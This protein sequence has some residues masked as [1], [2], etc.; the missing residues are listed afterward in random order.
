MDD[1]YIKMVEERDTFLTLFQDGYL[2][3]M[4][5]RA[6]YDIV[7][8]LTRLMRV[9]E[10]L[11][12]HSYP[13]K[14]K[15]QLVE[16]FII[17]RDIDDEFRSKRIEIINNMTGDFNA[18]KENRN[19]FKGYVKVKIAELV[20][21]MFENNLSDPNCMVN[22]FNACTEYAESINKANTTD[23]CIKLVKVLCDKLGSSNNPAIMNAI[24]EFK[25]DITN[26]IGMNGNTL[27][28]EMLQKRSKGYKYPYSMEKRIS[29]KLSEKEKIKLFEKTSET[30][31]DILISYI[32]LEIMMLDS[33]SMVDGAK[34]V[35]FF[36]KTNTAYFIVLRTLLEENPD[37]IN[38]E[39]FM[40]NVNDIMSRYDNDMAIKKLG[41]KL[42]KKLTDKKA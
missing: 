27:Y 38:N 6:N 18:E 29:K 4:Q 15:K 19:Y 20:D 23:D 26:H 12:A 1:K 40:S 22:I 8:L 2:L 5:K 7:D 21:Y 32:D 16:Q 35:G 25:K 9:I 24:K 30:L 33:H 36:A 14:Y 42:Y 31:I 41:K 17:L 3:E 34:K 37:L 39:V 11:Q 10:F 28:I 13:E